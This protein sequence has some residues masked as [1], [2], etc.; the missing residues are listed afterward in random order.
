M[1]YDVYDA[2]QEM[3]AEEMFAEELRN[4]GFEQ[5]LV[6]ITDEIEGGRHSRLV[7]ARETAGYTQASEFADR[8]KI[9][10]SSYSLYENG[11]RTLSLERGITFARYLKADWQ[12]LMFGDYKDIL[13]TDISEPAEWPNEMNPNLQ[14]QIVDYDFV[15][16]YSVTAAAGDGTVVDEEHVTGFLAFRPGWLRSVTNAP[17]AALAIITV[18]GDSMEP[19]MRDGDT[20]LV[21]TSVNTIASD[22]IYTLKNDDGVQVKRLTVNPGTK[23]ISVISD[24]TNYR[25]YDDIKPSDLT[26][27]GRVVWLGRRI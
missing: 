8:F 2:Q 3:Q 11:K 22:G 26:I 12:Y 19:T 15:P 14:K 20:V 17:S 18:R 16:E 9:P 25:T 1:G 5:A 21:D 6:E 10:R 13:E 27:S 23:K 24:N 7:K 4:E